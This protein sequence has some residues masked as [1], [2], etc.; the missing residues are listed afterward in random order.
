MHAK[1]QCALIKQISQMETH[2]QGIEREAQEL[3]VQ[4]TFA[5]DPGLVPI[6]HM[7]THR[8]SECLKHSVGS[9][10]TM[11]THYEPTCMQEKHSH[12]YN[13]NQWVS[14]KSRISLN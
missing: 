14:L 10:G 13:K 3:R 4:I 6:T 2:L 7:E 11:H 5:E 8:I 12:I 9:V 1:Q